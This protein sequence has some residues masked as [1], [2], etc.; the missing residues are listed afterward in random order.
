[1]LEQDDSNQVNEAEEQETSEEE[2]EIKQPNED[3]QKMKEVKKKK[4]KYKTKKL[5][6]NVAQ[7]KYHVVRYVARKLYNMRLSTY[8]QNNHDSNDEKHEWDIMWTDNGATVERLHK[9]KPYQR[10]N[11]F[12][13]MYALA[14]KDHLARNLNKMQ[15]RFPLDYNFFPQTWLLPAEYGDFRKQFDESR[16]GK[17]GR[18][19]YIS[20][21]EASCQ[22]RGIFLTRNLDDF[23]KQG[24]Y[25]VQKYLHKPFLIDKLKFDL[26]IYVLVCGV[27]PLR[28]Y[29]Y[30]EGL[31]RLATCEY[32]KPAEK[33]LGNLYMH[34]TNYAINK[35]S[36]KFQANKGSD[37]DDSGH[38]RSLTFAMRYIEEHGHD[39]KKVLSNIKAVIIKTMCSV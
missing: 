2:D 39:S 32:K 10:I 19:T 24:H 9:M 22:G 3:S 18:K 1:M 37:K 28:I 38:K 17:P 13:G 33:N 25:V 20:K 27:D 5:V 30:N 14:R 36:D 8:G 16:I 29:F 23:E 31:C 34:L 12:P 26:R 7:T 4:I 6:M 15:K 11:H 21:P 35:F